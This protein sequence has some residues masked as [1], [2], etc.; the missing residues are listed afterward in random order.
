MFTPERVPNAV[1]QLDDARLPI[2]LAR[3]DS[4]E[5]VLCPCR[6][7]SYEL[8]LV[9]TEMNNMFTGTDEGGS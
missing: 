1:F 9:L 8:L 2:D 4:V 6:A 7:G 3:I 5:S